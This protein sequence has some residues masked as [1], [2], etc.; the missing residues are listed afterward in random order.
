M[1]HRNAAPSPAPAPQPECTD[2]KPHIP[3]LSALS[4]SPEQSSAENKHSPY[5]WESR[6]LPGMS[7]GSFQLNSAL[8]G[9]SIHVNSL[10]VLLFYVFGFFFKY[11]Y[12][13]SPITH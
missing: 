10:Y 2:S 7:P 1:K 8:K 5:I 13:F 11:Y 4:P 6:I 12:Y 9:V 3:A